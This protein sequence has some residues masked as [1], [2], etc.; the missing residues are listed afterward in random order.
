MY[1]QM[2]GQVVAAREPLHTEAARVGLDA[3]VRA[4]V[5][6]QLVG[7]GELPVAALPVTLERALSA[8]NVEMGKSL[9]LN[10]LH[11]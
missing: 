9:F 8:V 10:E 6:R 3:I 7:A 11:L 5:P 4:P 1:L 2:F